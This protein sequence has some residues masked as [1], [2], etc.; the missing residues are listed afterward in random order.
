VSQFHVSPDGKWVAYYSAESGGSEIWAASFPGFTDRRKVSAGFGEAPIWR[1]DGKELFF[2][3]SGATVMAVDVKTGAN[4]ESG[5][6]RSILT[7]PGGASLANSNFRY[8]VSSDGKRLLMRQ[9]PE[10]ADDQVEPIYV[11]LNWPS[12]GK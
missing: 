6:P 4:F 5:T 9:P 2:L 11:I 3:S 7:V 12:L 10:S 1:A 8:A